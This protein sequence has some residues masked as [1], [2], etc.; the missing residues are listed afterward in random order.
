MTKSNLHINATTMNSLTESRTGRSIDALLE[1]NIFDH[2]DIASVEDEKS[3]YKKNKVRVFSFERTYD[4]E[5]AGLLIKIFGTFKWC[6]SVYKNL[7]ANKYHVINCHSINLLPLSVILKLK[8]K[9][10]LIYDIHE[11]E[12]ETAAMTNIRKFFSKVLENIFIRFV[13]F[14]IVVSEPI[15][16]WYVN[17]YSLQNY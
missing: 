6:L 11:L 7:S 8:N 14:T 10:K 2:I 1:Y 9:S 16:D 12:T 4:V 15:K 17:K 3:D 13:D 5:K